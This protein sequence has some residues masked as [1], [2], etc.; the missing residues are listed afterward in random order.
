MP[1]HSS[2]DI[3]LDRFD[4]LIRFCR[5]H[6]D[7]DLFLAASSYQ[8]CGK[9]YICIYP[10]DEYTIDA[11]AGREDLSRFCFA[12]ARPSFGYLSYSYG[13]LLRGIRTGKSSDFPLGHIKKYAT[14]LL[15]D[16][17]FLEVN[18]Y[19]DK[20]IIDLDSLLVAINQP[21]RPV[22]S[23]ESQTAIALQQSLSRDEYIDG[24]RCTIDY[25]RDGYIYQLNLTIKYSATI[26]R[27]DCDALF[28]HFWR[29]YPASHY[30]LFTSGQYTIVS[31][32]PERFLSISDG[33]VLSQPIKGTLD[34]TTR[35]TSLIR[36]LT[37][38]PKESAELSMIVDMV[39]NDISANCEVGSVR[40]NRHKSVFEVDNLL[41]MYSDVTGQLMENKTVIDLL[42]DAFPGASITGC[43]KKKAMELIDELEPHSRDAYCGSFFVIKGIKNMESSIAIRTG[44]YDMKSRQLSF[45]AGS[46]IVVES[47]PE[48][49]Y[50]ETTAKARKF[51]DYLHTNADKEV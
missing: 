45:F 42:V 8:D 15:Y 3:S 41:Q 37:E 34:F 19:D 21:E 26:N 1:L 17:Q 51:L 6:Y 39:R 31:T 10:T 23:H 28:N 50:L 16:G 27:F 13:Q 9:S 24:T 29:N 14:V 12:D 22:E 43:P 38:S 18:N 35:D 4:R 33:E 2:T 48:K 25:I 47:D 30:A 7:A 46:G 49:E 40:V 20:N 11:T 32:S 36:Q 44:Y 5:Q